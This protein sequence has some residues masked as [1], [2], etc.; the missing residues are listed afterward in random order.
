MSSGANAHR[1]SPQT[2]HW[3]ARAMSATRIV[4]QRAVASPSPYGFKVVTRKSLTAAIVAVVA[5][6]L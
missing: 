3:I 6:S 5:A 4:P 2:P 1:D